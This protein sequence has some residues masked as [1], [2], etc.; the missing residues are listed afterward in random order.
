[1]ENKNPTTVR[2]T[3]V[4]QKAK[5]KLVPI[6]GLKRVLSAGLVLFDKLS[7]DEQKQAIAEANAPGPPKTGK[8]PY[9]KPKTLREAVRNIVESTKQTGQE[10]GT[11][12]QISKS[13]E[14]L[15][16]ELK[17]FVGP[18]PKKKKAKKA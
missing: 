8:I 6:Y 15:W 5:D 1:M 7:S 3:K 12:I 17:R 2:L 16:D 4:A 11:V 14:K 10:P 18:E 9:T 13:D